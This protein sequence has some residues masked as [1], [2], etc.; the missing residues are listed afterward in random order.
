MK[1]A[2]KPEVC[3]CAWC[4]GEGVEEV[5]T[6]NRFRVRCGN[7]RCPVRPITDGYPKREVARAVWNFQQSPWPREVALQ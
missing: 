4:Q 7:A 6:A 5:S 3:L 1:R 2:Y